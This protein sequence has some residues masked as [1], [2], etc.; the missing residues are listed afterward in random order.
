M[1]LWHSVIHPITNHF[2]QRRGRFI[3]SNFPDICTWKIC[4]LGGSRHFWEKLEIN[5]LSFSNITIYNIS[6]GETDGYLSDISNKIQV[7]IYDGH[8]IP[9]E[10]GEFDLIV[11]NSVLEHVPLHE[12]RSLVDEMMRVANHIFIQTP[13]YSFPIEP[14]FVIP[15]VHWLPRKLGFWLVHVSPWR[16]L[17]RPSQ[18]IIGGAHNCS[19]RES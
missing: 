6:S 10:D 16:L 13:A 9:S 7:Y 15:F 11:C 5:D 19:L 12:R 1:N 2:R 14:H 17:S 8:I 3:Q 18:K 4:D